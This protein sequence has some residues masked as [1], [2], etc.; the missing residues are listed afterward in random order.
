MGKIFVILLFIVFISTMG[1]TTIIP[2]IADN[3][4]VVPPTVASF[5]YSN[6][7]QEIADQFIAHEK[8]YK[9]YSTNGTVTVIRHGTPQYYS[10]TLYAQRPDHYYLGWAD[11][12]GN[13]TDI[14]IRNDWDEYYI[15]PALNQTW[16][17]FKD[18]NG[19][20][21]YSKVPTYDSG[22]DILEMITSSLREGKYHPEFLCRR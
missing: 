7:A 2:S 14:F 1:C 10:F 4:S 8:S 21:K 16:H 22:Y 15:T 3:K 6:Q 13:S 17:N 11:T 20:T 9:L 18:F 12:T 5:G 19:A